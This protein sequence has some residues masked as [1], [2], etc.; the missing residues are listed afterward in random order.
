[1]KEQLFKN[2]D[3]R[4]LKTGML[5]RTRDK[6]LRIILGKTAISLENNGGGVGLYRYNDDLMCKDST[7]EKNNDIME[8]YDEPCESHDEASLS[9]DFPWWSQE[10]RLL[11]HTVILW[12]RKE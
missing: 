6:K 11:R 8:I 3:K 10:D 5:V 7:S 9:A 4:N 1:M 2:F 12:Q